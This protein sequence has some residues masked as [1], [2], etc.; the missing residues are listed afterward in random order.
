MKTLF[1]GSSSYC[2]PLAVSL[3]KDTDL[4]GVVTS[5]DSTFGRNKAILPSPIKSYAKSN[6][7]SYFTPSNSEE[8]SRLIPDFKKLEPDI[9]VVADYGLLIPQGVFN[10][11][12]FKTIN[13]HFGKLPQYRGASPL[14]WSI[15]NGEKIIPVTFMLMDEGLDTGE[16]ITEINYETKGDETTGTLYSLLFEKAADSLKKVI[17]DFT[18]GKSKPHKQNTKNVRVTQ[19]LTRSDGYIPWEI[20]TNTINNNDN[21]TSPII[22]SLSPIARSA[23]S[24]SPFR[25]FACSETCR[26]ALSLYNLYRAL[27]PWPGLWTEVNINNSINTNKPI[28]KRLKILEIHLEPLTFNLVPDVV[29]LEGKKPVS[30]EQFKEAYLAFNKS[31]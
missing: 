12:V 11:P 2:L 9:G 26:R 8:L 28:K 13:V 29:Q 30:W 1:F 31:L 5:P 17:E 3:H 19:R 27:S 23:F 14:Q 4:I 20:F 16:I 6:Q 18:K 25:S 24:F 10:L 21:S 22:N 15:A 7:I